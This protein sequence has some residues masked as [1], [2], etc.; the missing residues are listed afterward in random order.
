[1]R[2]MRTNL[3]ACAM[4]LLGWMGS[5]DATHIIR[6]VIGLI[7]ATR[8]EPYASFLLAPQLPSTPWNQNRSVDYTREIID[9]V[10][11]NYPVDT[12]R[13]YVTG[14]SAGGF[15]TT[16]L[17]RDNPDLFAAAMPIAGAISIN[18]D[19]AA[20]IGQVPFWL[21]HGDRDPVV[22]VSRSRDFVAALEDAGGSPRYDEIVSDQHNVWDEVYFDH[23]LQRRGVYD[24]MFSQSLVST[25][26]EP[27]AGFALTALSVAM[28][29]GR[30]R[31]SAKGIR[32]KQVTAS[33]ANSVN[34][35]GSLGA[36]ISPRRR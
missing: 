7:D 2:F 3:L 4:A 31:Q 12:N 35:P 19:Q 23:L 13:L 22:S 28:A 34:H 16:R 33:L 36:P 8:S 25:I 6:N 27:G 1:M 15:G 26:P 5:E 20:R 24:W 17:V 9:D 29:F 10:I 11:Q 30:R 18:P 32:D 21:F 14:L